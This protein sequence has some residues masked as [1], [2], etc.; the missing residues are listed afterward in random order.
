MIFYDCVFNLLAFMCSSG[1]AANDRERSNLKV[2]TMSEIFCILSTKHRKE[3]KF[4]TIKQ[5]EHSQECSI[6]ASTDQN[7][8]LTC[9]P[10]DRSQPNLDLSC[11]GS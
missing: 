10:P 5:I 1:L 7:K 4:E 9:L 3:T 11:Q 8:N 6:P 2:R